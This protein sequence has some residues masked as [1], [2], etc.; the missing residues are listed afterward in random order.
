MGL[1]GADLV[2]ILK[3]EIHLW[4]W[5]LESGKAAEADENQKTLASVCKSIK[6][7]FWRAAK[8]GFASQR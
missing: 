4:I 2:L 1:F 3:T 6:A 8:N 5:V 7:L